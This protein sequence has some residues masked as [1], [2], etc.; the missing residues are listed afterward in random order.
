MK[1]GLVTCIAISDPFFDDLSALHAK[2][3]EIRIREVQAAFRTV[4]KD[5]HQNRELRE[6][7]IIA[8]FPPKRTG[9]L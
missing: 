5:S 8:S 3:I 1:A 2:K 9:I 4:N 6:E 7:I